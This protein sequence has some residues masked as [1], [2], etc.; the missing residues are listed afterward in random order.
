MELYQASWATT[1]VGGSVA[2]V[3]EE[4]SVMYKSLRASK[5]NSICKAPML[6]GSFSV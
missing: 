5:S 1:F 4:G 2:F 6:S 3:K